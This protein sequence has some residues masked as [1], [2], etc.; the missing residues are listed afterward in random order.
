MTQRHHKHP[1]LAPHTQKIYGAVSINVP[2]PYTMLIIGLGILFGLLLIYSFVVEFTEHYLVQGYL[3]VKSGMTKVYPLHPGIISHCFVKEG[4]TVIKNDALY[5]ISTIQDQHIVHH[6]P[7]YRLLQNQLTLIDH[8]LKRKTQYLHTLRPLLKQ[9][10][11][12]QASYQETRDQLSTLKNKQ[13]ELKMKIMQYQDSRTYVIRAPMTGIIST[14]NFD[15]GQTVQ[16]DQPLL[17]IIPQNA[18]LVAQLYIPVSKSGFITPQAPIVLR[19]DAYPYRYFGVA[20]AQIISM[21]QSILRDRDEDK[22]IDIGEPY[23]KVIA[24]LDKQSMMLYGRSHR[25]YQGM[26]C[27]ALIAGVHKKIW[28]WIFDPMRR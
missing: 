11:L 17:T 14:L 13:H 10:Y 22:P 24:R 20:T 12:S 1:T 8:T 3:N 18:E 6:T 21:T 4:Q 2:A 9:H 26:T 23:Y 25:L 7:E 28:R 19:Y 15:V 27:S 16:S 5:R